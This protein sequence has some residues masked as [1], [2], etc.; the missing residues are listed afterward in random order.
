MVKVHSAAI[1]RAVAALT[2]L[3]LGLPVYPVS[4]ACNGSVTAY[5]DV[6]RTGQDTI[7]IDVLSNDVGPAGVA[8]DADVVSES[9]PGT[10]TVD[11]GSLL[12]VP[13]QALTS[14]CTITYRA[15]YQKPGASQYV[16]SANATVTVT[17]LAVPESI[18]T[19]DFET[20]R[21]SAWASCT[22]CF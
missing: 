7:S 5:N 13:S 19:D 3:F 4:V 9:C 17:A 15:G 16:W 11:F 18:F 2:I 22:G 6:A 21:F 12:F 14:N 10:V 8:L 20:G 1:A